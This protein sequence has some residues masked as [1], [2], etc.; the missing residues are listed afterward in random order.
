ML[1]KFLINLRK[2]TFA[3]VVDHELKASAAASMHSRAAAASISGR[4][5][6]SSLVAGSVGLLE[7]SPLH[8]SRHSDSKQRRSLLI[9]LNSICHL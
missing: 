1:V 2:D 3:V 9:R 7:Q 6:I 5:P 8:E 4:V